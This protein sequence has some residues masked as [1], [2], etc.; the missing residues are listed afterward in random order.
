MQIEHRKLAS[1]Y[2]NKDI[3]YN[4]YGHWG[5]PVIMLPPCNANEFIF[6]EEGMIDSVE[7]LLND[8]LMKIITLPSLDAESL[9]SKEYSSN[10]K[11]HN[12]ALYLQMIKEEVLPLLQKECN[13]H[14]IGICGVGIGAFN[15]TNITFKNPDYIRFLISLSGTFDLKSQFKSDINISLDD[16]NPVTY[17]Q[18]QDAWI[19]NHLEMIF[20]TSDWDI[21]RKDNI[22]FSTLLNQKGIGHCLDEV[23]NVPRSW[24][25]W[26]QV[27]PNYIH[28]LISL[29]AE[30]KPL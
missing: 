14:R 24:N 16:F 4:V 18:H 8:G 15:A 27:F 6:E 9:K 2:L 3:P 12:Y 10:I 11:I 1:S 19:Y 26:N 21:C 7:H 22:E 30:A 23:K 20:S 28:N 17:L 29:T 25:L 5:F 13:V